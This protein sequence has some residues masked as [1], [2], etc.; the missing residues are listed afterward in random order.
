MEVSID[1][2]RDAQSGQRSTAGGPKTRPPRLAIKLN[3]CVSKDPCA[4][5]GFHTDPEVG[6]ELFLEGTWALVC[7]DCGNKHAPALVD[8]LFYTRQAK[9][10]RAMKREQAGSHED[11]WAADYDDPLYDSPVQ[12]AEDLAPVTQRQSDPDDYGYWD[13]DYLVHYPLLCD[14]PLVRCLPCLCCCTWTR[15]S[16]TKSSAR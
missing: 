4:L 13:E 5:C 6:P 9:Y 15:I 8:L 10:E 2:M 12:A 7:Y 11:P 16:T 3:N 1:A 14:D